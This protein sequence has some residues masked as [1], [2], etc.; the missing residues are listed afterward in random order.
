MPAVTVLA[1]HEPQ[2]E[3]TDR[4]GLFATERK[5]R[6]ALR[7]LAA[8][9]RLCGALLGFAG[10]TCVCRDARLAHPRQLMQL[11]RA[12]SPLRLQPWPY[13]GPIAVRERNTLHVFDR[14]EHLGSVRT[15]SDMQALLGQRRN[16][17][18]AQVYALLTRKL[19]RLPANAVRV[20]AD[21]A[22]R[23]DETWHDSPTSFDEQV[24]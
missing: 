4:F 3:D 11:T 1:A 9:E 12:L 18:D 19:A 16:G 6:N 20:I 17:F 8:N 23:F 22:S 10:A 5:A 15:F 2:G 14:W 7:K 13:P 24:A 21:G